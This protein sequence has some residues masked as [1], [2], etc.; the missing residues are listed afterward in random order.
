MDAFGTGRFVL[1]RE[2]VHSLE[3]EIDYYKISKCVL[4]REVFFLLCPLF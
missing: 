2:V 1:Y 4:Y 3:V